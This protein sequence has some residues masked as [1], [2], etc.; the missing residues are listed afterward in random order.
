[1]VGIEINQWEVWFIIV[2]SFLLHFSGGTIRLK[3]GGDSTSSSRLFKCL[4]GGTNHWDRGWWLEK[5]QCLPGGCPALYERLQH[6]WRWHLPCSH[7]CHPHA[8]PTHGG[9][10]S[11]GREDG[12]GGGQTPW[13]SVPLDRGPV[14]PLP[15]SL[16]LSDGFW[17]R[18][19]SDLASRVDLRAEKK[20][21]KGFQ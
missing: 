13:V 18:L 12:Q 14:L 19:S 1:M 6:S 2:E 15:L 3:K 10:P 9:T 4:A 8:G 11:D 5:D 7:K 17:L 16:W 21:T 20:D